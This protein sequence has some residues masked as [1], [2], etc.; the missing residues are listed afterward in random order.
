MVPR[1]ELRWLRAAGT[2]ARDSGRDRRSQPSRDHAAPERQRAAALQYQP[3]LFQTAGADCFS[4]TIP[5]ARARGR[6]QHRD[7][8]GRWLLLQAAGI[9]LPW[10]SRGDRHR[11]HWRVVQHLYRSGGTTMDRVRI[12]IIGLGIMGEQYAK[13][14]AMHPLAELVAVSEM[15][16]PRLDE[17]C[18]KFRVPNGYTEHRAMLDRKD[19]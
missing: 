6:H 11:A 5:D 8:G 16:Q 15:R 13:I 17:I 12:G 10:R 19:L 9:S 3:T 1:Q 4:F 7:A 18:A 14:C 2:L